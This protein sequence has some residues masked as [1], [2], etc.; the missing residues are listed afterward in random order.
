MKREHCLT[1][2][3][4]FFRMRRQWLVAAFIVVIYQKVTS[5]EVTTIGSAIFAND[6]LRTD[7]PI[8]VTIRVDAKRAWQ[9]HIL[10]GSSCFP[11]DRAPGCPG[12]PE[13]GELIVSH[14]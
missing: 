3:L 14:G 11:I 12:M 7:V 8:G 10:L 13:A 4:R 6:T 5:R 2:E 9:G 1:D